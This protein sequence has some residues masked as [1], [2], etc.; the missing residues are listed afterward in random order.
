MER[1]LAAILAADVVGYSRL[2]G[3]DEAGTLARLKACEA[4]VIEPAVGGHG[5]RIV[6]RMGDGYLVEFASVVAAVECGLDWQ[7]KAQAPIAF[8]IGIHLGD[9]MVD[10]DDIYGDGVNVAARIEA[11]ADPG[12][13]CLSEDAQRQVRGKI[14]AQFEDLGAQELKNIAEPLRVFKV[15]AGEAS[16]PEINEPSLGSLEGQATLALAPFRHVGDPSLSYIADGLTETLG[17]AL[18][19]FEEFAFVGMQSA[20][21]GKSSTFLLE[22]SVQTAGNRARI[23]VRLSETASGREVWGNSYDQT[24]DDVFA[25][26]DEVAGS[27]A[28]TMGEA[29]IEEAAKV[30]ADKPRSEFT[31]YDWT[32]LAAQHLHRLDRD[33]L[34]AAR[35]AVDRALVKAP[36]L[37]LAKIILAWTYVTELINGWPPGRNDAFD[38]S[39]DI[40]RDLIKQNE[41]YDQAHRLIARLYHMAGRHEEALKHS[42]RALEINP[43]NSDMMISYGYSLI[44]DGDSAEGLAHIERA[45]RLNPYA[46]A[47]YRVY[48]GLGRF[49]NGRH[50]EAIST[51]QGLSRPIGS[52]RLFL[53]ASL[54]CAD[55][56]PEAEAVIKEHLAENPEAT[57]T[58]IG[59]ALP[60]KDEADRSALLDALAMAGMPSGEEPEAPREQSG[61]SKDEKPSIAVLPFD[62]MSGDPEQEYFSDGLAE[63]IITELS[64]IRTL[65]VVARNSTFVYKGRSVN[66]PEIAKELGI[67]YVVEGSVR[68]A[69]NRVRVTAQLIEAESGS[70]VFAERFE[71]DMEDIFALQDEITRLIV[72]S[73]DPA[74]RDNEIRQALR[75]PPTNLAAWDH[76]LRGYWH[77]A[78]YEREENAKAHSELSK[79]ISL[80]PNLAAAHSFAALAHF[81]DAWLKWTETTAASFEQARQLAEK[82]LALDDRDAKAHAIIS[83]I[84]VWM[85]R[86]DSGLAAAERAVALNANDPMVWQSSAAAL[87]FDGQFTEAARHAATA[88]RLGA[89]EPWRW[90]IHGARALAF[91]GAGDFGRAIEVAQEAIGIR[92]GYVTAQVVAVAALA[93]LGRRE[94]AERERDRLLELVPDFSAATLAHFPYRRER[95]REDLLDGL[96]L[97]GL[98][99]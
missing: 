34:Q 81:C 84:E 54:A 60:M 14:E 75:K 26:Q 87:L 24:T 52:S 71:R 17:T 69:G 21:N 37:H 85:G 22:G 99:L 77:L 68:R 12:S 29:V 64:R 5:G 70:H 10:A 15:R 80:D 18:A 61:S 31:A 57:L 41:R 83:F 86:H 58:K 66:V 55:R 63:D 67:G 59:Q 27:I 94:E 4:E 44:L 78:K 90:V 95:Y 7:A 6:K 43:Y 93:R 3:A 72:T 45:C 28:S 48:L 13:L 74:I 51:L 98:T 30:L 53:A 32:L 23:A 65:R 89:H 62:N 19:L 96:R 9:V 25:L 33:E 20:D 40:A 8:R 2:M 73:V 16:A 97:S 11:L 46:P 50:E 1:K 91:Y 49:L 36:D 82:A 76:A 38:F 39:L 47:F 92:R 35:D 79:A 88:A 42:Q 56:L